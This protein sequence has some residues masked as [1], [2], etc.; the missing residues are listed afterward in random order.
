MLTILCIVF[1][2]Q[3]GNITSFNFYD[4]LADFCSNNGLI[5]LSL[6][7]T[8]DG[9]LNLSNKARHAFETFQ[10]HDL[11]VQRLSYTK[12]LPELKFNLDTFILLT[13]T[14]ILS[15]PDTFQ[16][17]LK[18]IGNHKIRKTILVFTDPLSILEET[19]LKNVLNDYISGNA[20][21]T[22]LYQRYDNITKY[23][24]II[25]I[26]NN[27]KTLVQDIKFDQNRELVINIIVKR[28]HEYA[29]KILF[30]IHNFGN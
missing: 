19:E 18:N 11:R 13:E 29:N 23:L 8:N 3:C 2:I 28:Q 22:L 24:N 17:Y 5:F 7:T 1:S 27:T 14:K 21:F 30:Q 20:W 26:S 10:K 9:N 16:I 4:D 15:D 25:S 12:L 6:T